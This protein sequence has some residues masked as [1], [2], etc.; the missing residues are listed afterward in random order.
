MVSWNRCA[1]WVT[2]PIVSRNDCR[3]ASRTS[4]PPTSTAPAVT[5]YTRGTSIAVV[6]L[7]APDGPTSATICPG[8]TVKLTP[9][10][11]GSVTVRSS[12]GDVLERGERHLARRG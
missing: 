2:T 7:P 8:S 3:V 4:M 9:R 12:V 5:S 1:S 6:D 10:S 11:T